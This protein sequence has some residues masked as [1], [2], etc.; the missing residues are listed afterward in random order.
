M[1]Y[2]PFGKT[3]MGV[4]ALGFGCWETSGGYG[5]FDE[6]EVVS[7][8][9]RALDVGINCFDTAQSYGSGRSEA[10]LAKALDGRRDEA[11]I[12][13][14][15]GIRYPNRER[16][17]D[18]RRFRVLGSIDESLKLLKTDYVDVYLVHSPDHHTPFEETMLALEEVVRSGKA[19]YAGISNFNVDQMQECVK[20][21]H[22]DVAQHQYHLFDRT[23]EGKILPFCRDRGIGMMTWG[24]LAHG[25]LAGAFT[26]ETVFEESD[27]RSQ[28]STGKS[29]FFTRE[30][31]PTS[32]AVVEE[33]K[34][35]AARHGKKV[36]H[37]ALR[38]AL[39][40]PGVSVA[41]VG[42]RRPEEVDDCVGCLDWLLT[43]SDREDIDAIFSRFG[44]ETANDDWLAD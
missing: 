22:L 26:P 35:I 12:V 24:S 13:T 4:S 39:E 41:L 23:I 36:A 14:K 5:A 1:E 25:L 37:L 28:A 21:R 32:L 43:D 7:A 17:R 6:R 27:W 29:R 34:A 18:S 42:F 15:F 2:R 11:I 44:I 30:N 20:T 19:R 33:L 31:F 40:N 38:W 10:I 16:G 8:V 3:E 9:H